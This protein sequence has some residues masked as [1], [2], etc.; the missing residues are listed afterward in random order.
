MAA[1]ASPY[2]PNPTSGSVYLQSENEIINEI[3]VTDMLGRI[4]YHN[5]NVSA[6]DFTVDLNNHV[7]GLY[8]FHIRTNKKDKTSKVLLN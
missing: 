6:S 5:K 3:I 4:V 8:L 7:K 2:Y 1:I